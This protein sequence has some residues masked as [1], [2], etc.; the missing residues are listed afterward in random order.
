M[1]STEQSLEKV[2]MNEEGIRVPGCQISRTFSLLREQ[3]EVERVEWISDPGE[4]QTLSVCPTQGRA[5]HLQ[6]HGLSV[7]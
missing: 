3:G 2:R 5:E 4:M 1:Y 6:R 7:T